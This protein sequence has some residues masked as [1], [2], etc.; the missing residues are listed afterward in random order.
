MYKKDAL[1]SDFC[2]QKDENTKFSI[3]DYYNKNYNRLLET[4]ELVK[5]LICDYSKIDLW[6][7]G[8]YTMYLL[9]NI[10]ELEE[11][12]NV[13]IDNNKSKWGM[14]ICGKKVCG[15]DQLIGNGQDVILICSMQNGQEIKNQIKEMGLNNKTYII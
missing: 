15:P 9:A 4:T 8:S 5:K 7:T 10:P 14:N 1:E 13:F 2:I 11:H 12:I 3:K 6:G